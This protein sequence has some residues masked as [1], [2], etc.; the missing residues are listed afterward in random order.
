M[1]S[2]WHEWKLAFEKTYRYNETTDLGTTLGDGD[3]NQY[4]GDDVEKDDDQSKDGL[5]LPASV[6][7]SNLVSSR[8]TQHLCGLIVL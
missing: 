3:A 6:M 8:A 4:D 7:T 5:P 1:S 2:E